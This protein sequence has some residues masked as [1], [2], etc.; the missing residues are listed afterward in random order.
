MAFHW[1]MAMT[2]YAHCVALP[3]ARNR[4]SFA[5]GYIE[6][7]ILPQLSRYWLQAMTRKRPSRK[8]AFVLMRMNRLF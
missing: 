3:D 7:H 5:H 6:Q 4:C 2:D 1:C 8:S